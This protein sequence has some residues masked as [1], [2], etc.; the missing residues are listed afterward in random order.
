MTEKLSLMEKCIYISHC[1]KKDFEK[2]RNHE[3]EGFEL[4]YC[5]GEYKSCRTYQARKLSPTGLINY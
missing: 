4:R 1:P 2:S 5:L 3:F